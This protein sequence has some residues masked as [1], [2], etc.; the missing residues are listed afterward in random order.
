MNL[1]APFD[2]SHRPAPQTARVSYAVLDQALWA[3]FAGAASAAE[4]A[5]A[6]LALLCRNI[7]GATAGAVVLGEPETGPFAP[8]A[9]W[10]DATA[11]SPALAAAAE[12]AMARRQPVLTQGAGRE[13]ACPVLVDGALYGTVAVATGP[14]GPAPGE[15]L[16]QVR[17]GAG[18]IEVLL[19]RDQARSDARLRERT[20][21]ALD[22]LGGILEQSRFRAACNALVTDLAMRLGC[23]PVSIG[24][25]R[26]RRTRI[27]A[28]SHAAGFGSRMNLI[29]DLGAAMDEAIDQQAIVLWPA[30]PAWDYRV[31][32][33]HEDLA[34]IH[35]ADA[36]LTVPIQ[37]DGTI[38][39]ALTF[40]RS[41]GRPFDEAEVELCDAVATIVGPVLEEKRRND[42]TA[43]VKLVEAVWSQLRRLLG[44][45][46]FGRKLATL[47]FAGVVAVLMTARGPFEIAAP[48]TVEGSIQRTVAAPFAGYLAAENVRAGAIVRAGDVLA[49]LDDQ[50][51]TLERLRL[52][53]QRAQHTT[54]YD[55]ALAKR[56]RAQANIMQSQIRQAES[57]VALIDEQLARTRI[58]APFDGIVVSGDLSQHVGTTV[59]RGQEL[60]RIAP[61][62]AY[63][64]I[65]EVGEADIA[66]IRTGQTG[67]LRVSSLPDEPLDYTIERI[68]PVAEQKDGRNFFR[69]E[70]RL[71]AGAERLR[72][73]MQGIARTGVDERLLA[74][75]WTRSL[76]NWFRLAIWRWQP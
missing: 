51:L 38:I 63:R 62:D 16:R 24:F 13:V 52:T 1:E 9:H 8:A 27:A 23:D 10:P 29:R 40:E 20:A 35:K 64:V 56:D 54:E 76:V 73:S 28:V 44:P 74:S 47:V 68:T 48:A 33:A 49:T 57:Q 21:T 61:L 4:F 41:G 18:W 12:Q 3:Q 2:A 67:R 39:G 70:A 6:W 58:T 46:H 37:H 65:I 17:W 66:E 59:D 75:I 42:R 5:G 22:M 31:S 32:L 11:A 43:I 36:V 72:P 60:F 34:R 50:D 25:L 14:D 19:R 55:Q 15:V 7:P 53:T 26:R 71:D 30:D 69:V 45:G